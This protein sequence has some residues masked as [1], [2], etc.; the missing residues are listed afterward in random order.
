[1][2]FSAIPRLF[3]RKVA[4]RDQNRRIEVVRLD[5]QR[6]AGTIIREAPNSAEMTLALRRLDDC[7]DQVQKAILRAP[8]AEGRG[9][10]ER[11]ELFAKV[12]RGLDPKTRAELAI[13][14]E[15]SPDDVDGKAKPEQAMAV[16]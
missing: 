9:Q 6:L 8:Q 2:D 3:A 7:F 5:V 13:V 10:A 12:D 15:L 14:L 11:L 16:S 1:M 4:T